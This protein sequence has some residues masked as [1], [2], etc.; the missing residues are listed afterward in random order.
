MQRKQEFICK[1]YDEAMQLAVTYFHISEEKIFLSVLE[2][3]ENEVKV[4]ALVDINLA[5]EGKK[6]IEAILN[7]MNIEYQLEIRT[8]KDA[9]GDEKEIH[10]NIHSSENPLIIGNKGKTLEAL[11]ILVRNL[12]QT[13]TKADL[14]VNVDC[15]DYKNH[16]KHQLEVLA[17][18]TAKEV[19]KTK[20]AVKL[21]PMTSY[22]RRIIHAK[23]AEWKDVYTESEGEGQDR[24]IVI[25]PR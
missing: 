3:N 8:L 12:L 2:E 18:K 1:T 22:E 25:K 21:N 10:Y 23:L 19:A 17:T 14:V 7:T 6:Y 24:A 16:R 11:Q 20:V 15:G 4:E 9:N 5:L 13:Y